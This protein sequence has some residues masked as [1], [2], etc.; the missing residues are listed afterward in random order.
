MTD[1]T[2]QPELPALPEPHLHSSET[3]D[4]LHHY[5]SDQM[6]AYAQAAVLA[7]RDGRDQDAERYRFLRMHTFALRNSGFHQFSFPQVAQRGVNLFRGSVAQHLD[8]A[9]DAARLAA[10]SH[11][12]DKESGA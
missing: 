3:D 12:N 10:P 5:T 6:R 7:D 2:Q 1:T 9:V 4:G 11:P 8:A